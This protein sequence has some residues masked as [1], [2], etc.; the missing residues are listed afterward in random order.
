[1][2]KE[3]LQHKTFT[4]V[5]WGF[6]E[7]FSTQLV[8]LVVGVILAR[9]LSPSD[10]GLIAMA[11]VFV[12]VC[13]IIVDSGFGSALIRKKNR[14]AVDYSTVFDI[15]VVLSFIMAILLCVSAPFIASFY[16]EPM[17]KYIV[18]VNGLYLFLGA[19]VS[20]QG[21]KMQAEMHFKEHSKIIVY[22]SIIRGVISVVMALMGFGVWSLI[23]PNLITIFTTALLYWHILHWFPGITF[24]LKSAK[25]MFSFGSKL[26]LSTIINTVYTNLYPMII[27][28]KFSSANLGYY[29]KANAYANLPSMT[30]ANVIGGVAYPV[31][32]SIQDDDERL[33]DVYRR[34]LRLS[35]YVV[36]P[37]MIGILVLARPLIIALITEKWLTSVVYLQILCIAAMLYPIHGLNLNL[38]QVKG[39][40]DL[41]LRLEII[42]KIIGV[43]FII[44]TIRFGLVWLCVGIVCNSFIGLFI[45]TYYTGKLIDVGLKR[46]MLDLL[47]TIFFSVIMGGTVFVVADMF[48]STYMQISAGMLIGV[49]VYY[50]IS[51]ISHSEDLRYL[52]TILKDNLHF[53]Y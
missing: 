9:L 47:P 2:T 23:L 24:S 48:V 21:V 12:M 39:R 44:V 35:A 45:N 5:V 1:M 27:G 22:N 52:K 43:I 25:E 15:N 26:L 3:S 37:I 41:F 16:H 28:K 8:T 46:Q 4:G 6:L 36:F 11:E 30:I 13:Q 50:G 38:L 19:F 49:L 10:Y 33:R 14:T 20:I 31:L 53:K 18:W 34:I 7:K 29:S 32:S 42:K 51:V 17:L 40:S